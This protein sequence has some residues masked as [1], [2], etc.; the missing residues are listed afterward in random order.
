MKPTPL[1]VSV[2]KQNKGKLII[3]LVLKTLRT[4][5]NNFM[6]QIIA[7]ILNENV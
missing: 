1:N 2:N 4:F 7:K 6:L 3:Y 5:H